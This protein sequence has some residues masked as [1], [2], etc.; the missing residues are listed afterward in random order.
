[1][2]NWD[3]EDKPEKEMFY[4]TALKNSLGKDVPSDS[5]MTYDKHPSKRFYLR[6]WEAGFEDKSNI[7]LVPISGDNTSN[8]DVSDPWFS[9]SEGSHD[10]RQ[11]SLDMVQEII[12]RASGK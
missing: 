2:N 8:L 12:R 3:E 4:R 11:A 6:H 7:P 5:M 10:V 9:K 1:M